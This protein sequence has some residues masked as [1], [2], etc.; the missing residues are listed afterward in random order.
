MRIRIVAAGLAM[1]LGATV[2]VAPAQADQQ[3][4]ASGHVVPID[5]D[6]FD[7]GLPRDAQGQYLDLG[8]TAEPSIRP[9][10]SEALALAVSLATGG[11]DGQV[12]G[13]P[14]SSARDVAVRLTRSIAYRHQANSPGGWGEHWQSALWAFNAAFAGWLLWDD[15]SPAD[16]TLV[17]RMVVAEADRFLDYQVP[18]YADPDGTVNTP[19]DSKAEENAWNAAFLN[20]AVSMLP[21]HPNHAVWQHKA[22]E[23]MVSSYSRPADLQRADRVNGRPV[24]DWL[25]GSNIFDDG[26]LVNHS[27]IHP[28]YF[29]SIAQVA[30]APVA[31]GLAGLPTPRA[32]F[33]NADLV[34][35]ALVDHSFGSPPYGAPGGTIY[36]R[37]AT[38]RATSG[39][40]Y[41]QG[42]DWGTSRQLHFLLLDTLA[43]A[44]GFDRRASVPAAEWAAAHASRALEMQ[45]RF[46]DGRTYGAGSEDTYAGREEWVAL[47]AGR[48][49]L[50]RWLAHNDRLRVTDRAFPV[51]PADYP[52]AEF[53]LSVPAGLPLG[54]ATAVT[55]TLHS[56]S[57][58]P[59]TRPAVR[60]EVPPGWTAVRQSGGSGEV[61]PGGSVT[62]TWLV[63]PGGTAETGALRAVADYRHYGRA[64]QLESAAQVAVQP[65]VN[66]ALGRPVTVS[67]AL[68]PDTGGALAVDGGFTDASRWLSAEDDPQPSLTIELAE[69]TPITRVDV[70]SGY[71]RTN[72]DPTTTLKDFAVEVHTGD[73]WQRVAEVTD[74]VA[75]RVFEVEVWA[76]TAST[77]SE[78][79][80]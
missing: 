75:A 80:R 9:P 28:D 6:D 3:T 5:W 21:G 44:Y 19:G 43:D 38:G 17:E 15:L 53:R 27:R 20:L 46:T 10:G 52:G 74:N 11:Y 29:T 67:S 73:G 48:A 12:T 18:Y 57:A 35:D 7:R 14:R 25:N 59:L 23:L 50:T 8:G 54:K 76:A 56:L 71:V 4:H 61:P 51:R 31:Y 40:Y 2:L 37:D 45:A 26:T 70:H 77:P 69:P 13:V 62:S 33:F 1:L 64:R 60:L 68:R 58:A 41:P 63:T 30:G 32:A 79:L 42:N 16:R 47:L 22:L 65:G 49:Y 34:Y 24:R 66:V 78:G 36:L 39:I 72:N 55:A